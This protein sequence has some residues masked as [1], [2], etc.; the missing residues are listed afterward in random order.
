MIIDVVKTQK[1]MDHNSQFSTGALLQKQ[2][3]TVHRIVLFGQK[4]PMTK[5]QKI[6]LNITD[7]SNRNTRNKIRTDHVS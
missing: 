3:K 4:N 1:V 7:S 5:L 6:V 2:D